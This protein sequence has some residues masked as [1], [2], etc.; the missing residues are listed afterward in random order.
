MYSAMNFVG[1][2]YLQ[3]VAKHTAGIKELTYKLMT[4]TESSS[5]LD[6]GC[7]PGVDTT[8]LAGIVTNG[9]VTGI[10]FSRSMVGE[11]TKNAFKMGISKRV[12]HIQGSAAGLPFKEC[13]FDAV[14]SERMLQHLKNPEF[15]ISEMARVCKKNGKVVVVDCDHSSLSVDTMHLD[16]EWKLRRFRTEYLPNGYAGRVLYRQ[17]REAGLENLHIEQHALAVTDYDEYRFIT[18]M[19]QIEQAA[20]KGGN[21]TL[22]ELEVYNNELIKLGES[23]RFYA[24]MVFVIVAGNPSSI[25]G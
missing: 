14:R 15:A 5:V 24:Y 11:A 17:F 1:P 25:P 20:L 23:K 10:D 13:T 4:L 7:G 3:N 21:I 18:C 16:V 2:N 22:K 8:T 12:F 9:Y 19:D 6:V